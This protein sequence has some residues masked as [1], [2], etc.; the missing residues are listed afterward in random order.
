LD[1]V[2]NLYKPLGLTSAR[3]L[4]VV[5]AISGIRKSGHAG[6][7]DPLADG[8]L[9]ICCG[10]ATRLVERWMEQPKVYRATLRLDEHSDSFDAELPRTPVY[11][12]TPPERQAVQAVLGQFVGAI[13]QVPP[14]TSAVKVGGKRAY[15]LARRGLTPALPPRPVVIH[16][17]QLE[18]YDW[19]LLTISVTCGRGVYVRALVR[20]I[21]VG[22]GTGG[23][24]T[25][26][27]RTAV[28][29][30]VV[31]DAWTIDALRLAERERYLIPLATIERLLSRSE[32]TP[33]SP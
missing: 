30:L 3:A 6:T 26:L 5:R 20:D 21:G 11:V 33:R 10:R 17:I 32:G 12:E 31:E 19:P 7:L 14:A 1:G 15:E 2:I 4:D 9:P 28:G 29:P 22:L 23:C 18:K 27:T 25:A 24:L 16:G 8:V 13:E